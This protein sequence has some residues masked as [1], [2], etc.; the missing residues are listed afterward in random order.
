MGTAVRKT[1]WFAIWVSI[2]AV[3]LILAVTGIVI[4]VNNASSASGPEGAQPRSSIVDTETGAIAFGDGDGTMDTYLD[5]MCPICNQ[6]EQAFGPAITALVDDG[7]ITLNV[8]PIAILDRY[9]QGTEFSSRAAAAMYAVAAA[10]PEHTYDFMT[11]MFA[12]QPEENSAGLTDAQIIDVAKDAGVTVTTDLEKAITSG[13]YVDFVQ[14]LTPKTPV[15]PDA[16]GIGTPTI[17]VN[18]ETISLSTLPADPNDI[19]ALFE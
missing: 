4:A 3:V 10:D 9:S 12:N 1:N 16:S 11:E 17:A 8:H 18:G 5:F 2:A 6:F 19:G 7:S 15:A 13:A 14:K